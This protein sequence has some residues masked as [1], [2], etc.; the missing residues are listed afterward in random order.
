[1]PTQR[2]PGQCDKQ[3][4]TRH[5]TLQG[6]AA[7]KMRCLKIWLQRPRAFRQSSSTTEERQLI[8][9][10]GDKTMAAVE[11]VGTARDCLMVEP[12]LESGGC[13]RRIFNRSGIRVSAP[14][15]ETLGKGVSERRMP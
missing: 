7:F 2:R 12:R 4:G 5:W 14:S 8:D 1:M 6:R 3:E 10:G 15:V 13:G 11:I 9:T